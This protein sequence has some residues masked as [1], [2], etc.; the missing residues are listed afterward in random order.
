MRIYVS[1]YYRCRVRYSTSSGSF[2][3][4][5]GEYGTGDGQFDRVCGVAVWPDG[6]RVY[7]VDHLNNRVQYFDRNEPAVVPASIGRVKALFR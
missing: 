7:V 6:A 4:S 5:F 3:G 2:L 1:D